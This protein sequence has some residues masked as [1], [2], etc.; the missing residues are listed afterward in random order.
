LLSTLHK[1]TYIV[2]CI[3]DN[4]WHAD[5]V[6]NLILALHAPHALTNTHRIDFQVFYYDQDDE[7]FWVP[8]GNYTVKVGHGE[9]QTP[10][11]VTIH[12]ALPEV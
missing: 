9:T 10:L 6:E 2:I 12:K 3:C 1:H 4:N 11:I 7:G 5:V 8:K